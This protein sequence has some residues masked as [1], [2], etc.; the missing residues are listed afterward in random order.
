[1]SALRSKP[2]WPAQQQLAHRA[3]KRR[4]SASVA[5]AGTHCGGR[6][7][8]FTHLFC[9]AESAPSRSFP[10][11]TPQRLGRWMLFTSEDQSESSWN[12]TLAFVCTW[13][14]RA[15]P[16]A[17]DPKELIVDSAFTSAELA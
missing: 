6:G 8:R 13:P 1:M 3:E 4:R 11:I 5:A 10:Q 2:R 7:F 15:A 17:R 12:Q 14:T 16:Q 9:L